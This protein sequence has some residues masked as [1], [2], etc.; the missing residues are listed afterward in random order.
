[1]TDQM[2]GSPQ[3]WLPVQAAPVARTPGGVTLS[4]GSGVEA[5]AWWNPTTWDLPDL[6]GLG[7]IIKVGLPIAQKALGL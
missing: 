6:P 4:G 3:S 7:D 2:T 1:M 5:S